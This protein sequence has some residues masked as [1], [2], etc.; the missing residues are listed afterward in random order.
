MTPQQALLKYFG[1]K[2]FRKNQLEIIE[3][4]LSDKNVVAVL[5]TG[6]GKSI[7]YQVPALIAENFSIVVSPLIALMKDQVDSLNSTPDLSAFIN[8][9]MEFYETEKVLQNIAFGKT[10][11]LYVAPERLENVS[12]GERIKSLNPSFLF[13]DE[14]HC[15]SEWGHNFR[16]SYRKIKAFAEYAEIKNISAFTA[17]ATPEVVE[18]IGEQ[19]GLK[20]P[21][22]F[23][24]GFE[25][26]NL[27]INVVITKKKKQKC[28]ELIRQFKTPAIIYTSSRKKT[29]EVA[30]F[31]NM[32]RINCNYYHAGMASEGRKKI[33]EDFLSDN[34]PVI[35]ATNAFGMGIDKKDIRLVIHYNTP[36]SIENYYQEIGRAGRDNKPSFAFL[37]HD[38]SDINIHKFFISNA[39]PDRELIQNIY[40]GICDYAKV[41][42]GNKPEDDIPINGEYLSSYCKREINRGLLHTCLRNLENAGYLNII[43]EYNRKSTLQMNFEKN[44]LKGFIKDSSNNNIKV[45]LLSLLREFSSEIFSSK[46]GFTLPQL[47]HK[48]DISEVDLEET[49]ITLDNLGVISYK[50]L[51]AKENIKLLVPRVETSRLT[52]DY[53]RINEN[54]LHLQNK[55]ESMVD[56]VYSNDCRFRYILKYFGED[57]TNYKCGKCDKC[58]GNEGL[59]DSTS[60]Y[61]KEI[62]LRSV[63]EI[64]EPVSEQVL[65]NILLG[66]EKSPKYQ[67]LQAFGSC[68]NYS[69]N[70]L[71]TVLHTF[72]ESGTINK[73]PGKKTGLKIS[74]ELKQ[75][76]SQEKTDKI[77][78]NDFADYEKN[79]EL[80]NQLREIRTHAS[81]RF[82]QTGNIICPD[83]IMRE[84]AI[85]KPSSEKDLLKIKG[86]NQRMFNKI[87]KEFLEVLRRDTEKQDQ[88]EPAEKIPSNIKETFSLL[89]KGYGLKDI[90]SL[91]KLS[92]AVIS[93]QIESIIEYEPSVNISHLFEKDQLGIIND[94]LKKGFEDLKGLK[95]RLPEEITYPLI[96]IA[97]AKNKFTSPSLSSTAQDRR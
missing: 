63:S 14:A 41:A 71:K 67:K 34:V 59:T 5:P 52:I 19:L 65:I 39:N 27:H 3:A 62:L 57:V 75:K 9:T 74:E 47:S 36:G 20:K 77:S 73:I 64:S 43:S 60:E 12:F 56:L 22:V 28:F 18:D 24:K 49:L 50:R 38:D 13:V 2:N 88:N 96:R 79:L 33:Q 48:L 40:N 91:R 10:K 29:E 45:V 81:K 86:F 21:K 16:P 6:A 26:E 25:R 94:E 17:T 70:D 61:L 51:M 82:L 58:T 32:N 30:E 72:Y 54:Y 23:V 95:K 55:I 8:S 42:V 1:F 87:G 15:I 92:E 68:A 90:A 7:C 69:K 35:A 11:I 85:Q 76:F 84:I 78:G 44:R 93:M 83:N 89:K 37:L 4:I 46:V 53:K 80:F 97:V 66:T 31:L